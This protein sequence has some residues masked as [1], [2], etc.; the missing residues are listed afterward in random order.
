MFYI[1][2]TYPTP[3]PT[4]FPPPFP[5]FSVALRRSS[6]MVAWLACRSAGQSALPPSPRSSHAAARAHRV[7]CARVRGCRSRVRRCAPTT[8]RVVQRHRHPLTTAT[9]ATATTIA[10]ATTT[11]RRATTRH[12]LGTMIVIAT[13]TI[14]ARRRLVT[15]CCEPAAR[16]AHARRMI[17]FADARADGR[18][19]PSCT[20]RGTPTAT[21]TGFEG[22]DTLGA[23]FL[24]CT[25]S[26][27]PPQM[28]DATKSAMSV[29][30]LAD[31]TMMTAPRLAMTT[32]PRHHQITHAA[33]ATTTDTRTVAH[34]HRAM[35]TAGRL[36][37]TSPT[38][39][40]LPLRA[41]TTASVVATVG[42]RPLDTMSASVR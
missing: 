1:I 5:R 3:D 17:C 9:T 34:P 16:S 19:T 32:A 4:Y 27:V 8:T 37:V 18:R 15:V 12:R 13:T 39:T 14:A 7:C 21:L 6:S 38:A 33:D 26:V 10:R 23:A 24:S 30:R 41:T 29:R 36:R 11:V 35:T 31:T 20:L 2:Q 25:R 42:R 40:P 22:Q 28:T